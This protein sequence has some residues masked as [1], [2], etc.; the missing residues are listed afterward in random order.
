[1]K[2]AFLAFALVL[3]LSACKKSKESIS[4]RLQQADRI[5]L[6]FFAEDGKGTPL[7]YADTKMLDSLLPLVTE[8]T[9]DALKC[10]YDGQINYLKGDSVIFS[11]EFNLSPECGHIAFSEGETTEFRK[12]AA[13][14][15][16]TLARIK[17]VQ[18]ASKLE[19]LAWF[20]GKWTQIEGPDL[21][22]Y[23]NWTRENDHLY[24][25]KAWTVYHTDTV[26]SETIDL[27]WEGDDIFYIPTVKE[28][29]GPVRFKM[30]GTIGHSA[31][32]ENLEHDFPTKISYEN[33]GDS[34]LFAKISGVIKGKEVA[35]EFPLQRSKD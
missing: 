8:T 4:T 10:G 17:A 14:P 13:Q 23:E 35:K 21:V 12:L 26:H 18:N 25:G 34:V 5:E 30:T 3:A 15:M 19:K 29:A 7:V 27:L 31:V 1:M 32:F 11:G 28:N 20:L 9:S 16:S 6:T 2:N 22:S 33:R 24:K